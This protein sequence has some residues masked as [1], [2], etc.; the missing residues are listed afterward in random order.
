MI[1]ILAFFGKMPYK[2]NLTDIQPSKLEKNFEIFRF[3]KLET[4]YFFPD[5]KNYASRYGLI[6]QISFRDWLYF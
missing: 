6:G 5:T 3:V 2:F 1:Q 4:K